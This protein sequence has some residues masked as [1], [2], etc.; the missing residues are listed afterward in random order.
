MKFY[1]LLKHIGK[2]RRQRIG[3]MNASNFAV[4]YSAPLYV[5][6]GWIRLFHEGNLKS[7]TI[8]EHVIPLASYSGSKMIDD[9]TLFKNFRKTVISPICL[10][11]RS[12]NG[13]L[14][15][16]KTHE[17]IERPFV[18]YKGIIDV[19]NTIDG[20]QINCS[21]FTFEDHLNIMSKRPAYRTVT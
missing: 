16:I 10:I 9:R 4:F 19:Y 1:L 7:N 5:S 20:T 13:K 11:S 18:R 12:E 17:N 8:K 14:K 21:D 15:D 3:M 6:A 2:G